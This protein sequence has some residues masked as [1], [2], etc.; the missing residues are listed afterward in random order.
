MRE[1]ARLAVAAFLMLAA[2]A[3]GSTQAQPQGASNP[4][5]F[6]LQEATIQD[7]HAAYKAGTL[8]ARQLT[9]LYLNRIQ[10]Y[11]KQGPRIN[12]IIT[13][14]PKALEDADRLDAT[15]KASGFVGPLHGIPVIVKDQADTL[16][17]PMTMGSVMLKDYY[18]ARDAFAVAK[19]R[20]A[21]AVILGKSTLGEWGGGDT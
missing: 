12:S 15:M 1:L 11:D 7:I 9:Q 10:A 19:I 20:Q 2:T 21:G 5:R 13:I 17:M 14:N 18:P 16:G 6:R 3:C 4:P 8:T